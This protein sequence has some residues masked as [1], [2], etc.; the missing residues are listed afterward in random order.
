[1]IVIALYLVELF[2]GYKY[3]KSKIVAFFAILLMW[4]WYSFNSY[5][6][7]YEGY[8]SIYESF[9]GGLQAGYYYSNYE[10]CWPLLMYIPAKLN[11]TFASFR[12]FAG[13]VY[14][15]ILYFAIVQMTD[16][17]ALALALFSVFPFTHSFRDRKSVV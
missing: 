12:I 16:K 6:G 1:M 9:Q 3:P 5:C 15:V 17:V 8:K 7:D 4:I 10:P 2:L 14:V 11:M 13:T